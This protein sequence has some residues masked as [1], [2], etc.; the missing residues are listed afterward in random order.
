MIGKASKIVTNFGPEL[1][2]HTLSK[3]IQGSLTE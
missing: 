2:V 3:L 1:S